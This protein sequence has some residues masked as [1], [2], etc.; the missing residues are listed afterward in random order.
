MVCF[1]TKWYVSGGK[2]LFDID[3]LCQHRALYILIWTIWNHCFQLLWPIKE[4]VLISDNSTWYDEFI[5]YIHKKEEI[6]WWLRRLKNLPAMQKTQVCMYVCVC[7]LVA[8][9]CLTLFNP[10][11]CSPPGSSVHGIL[12]ARILEWVAI[13]F[14]S[15]C[16]YIYIMNTI[17]NIH[18]IYSY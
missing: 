8:Q 14:S 1:P 18:N 10:I 12:Q 5:W 4:N 15:M 13:P 9:S 3:S 17:Y 7:V 16:I 11:N 6:P 2:G